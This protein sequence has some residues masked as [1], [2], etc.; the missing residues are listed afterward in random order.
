MSDETVQGA[1]PEAGAAW[2]RDGEQRVTLLFTDIV[3]STR[4][5]Q[6]LGDRQGVE[7]IQSHHRLV[8]E[9]LAGFP[10]AAVAGTSG[11]SFLIVFA[12]PA[13]AVA[14]AL[15]LQ[16]RLREDAV[17]ES[18]PVFDRVGIHTG[19]VVVERKGDDIDVLGSDVDAA[20]RVMG[21]AEADQ[22]LISEEAC[23]QAR[24]G[25]DREPPEG[26]RK[27]RWHKHGAYR[28]R[29]LK[30]AVPVWEVGEDGLARFRTPRRH[31]PGAVPGY[32]WLLLL[33]GLLAGGWLLERRVPDRAS[34]ARLPT[35]TLALVPEVDPTDPAAERTLLDGIAQA[36]L[37]RLAQRKQEARL[38]LRLVP[39]ADVLE[40]RITGT[41]EARKRFGAT[42]VLVARW[43][44]DGALTRLS[45]TLYDAT[46]EDT[47]RS[48]LLEARGSNLLGVAQIVA[49]RTLAWLQFGPLRPLPGMAGRMRTV[50]PRAYRLYLQGVGELARYDPSLQASN[51]VA[52]LT[53]ATVED[54]AFA[55]AFAA[56]GE[57]QWWLYERTQDRTQIEEALAS[58]LRAMELATN[59]LAPAA[60]TLGLVRLG[61]GQAAL[62]AEAFQRA[63]AV[64]P[65]YT[66]ARTMLARAHEEAG[67]Y[68]TAEGIHQ[69]AVSQ[70]AGDWRA[71]HSLGVFYANRTDRYEQA[72]KCFRRVIELTPDNYAG[73]ANLGGL[74]FL[75]GRFAEAAQW[76]EQ[77]I[78][79]KPTAQNCS[80][81]ATI[82]FFEGEYPDAVALALQATELDPNDHVWWG[83]LADARRYA[84]P[85]SPDA[86]AAYRHAIALAEASLRVN[87]R[88]PQVRADLAVYH[89]FLD[90]PAAAQAAIA[91]TLRV[92]PRDPGV[93]FSLAL[94]QER[95]GN[96]SA[97]LQFLRDALHAGYPRHNMIRHPD[98]KS[99]REDAAAT[100]LLAPPA[101]NNSQPH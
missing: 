85:A 41:T 22:I 4:L 29:G 73:Y 77:S 26:L 38:P 36:S 90:E 72:E 58:T 40:E 56:L 83:N 74:L 44:R 3:G 49:D 5:K 52:E 48:E 30:Q 20:A 21:L 71:W 50:N 15:R 89:A 2:L 101:E 87:P 31:P 10:E 55:L 69:E 7:R 51:A 23:A 24:P 27:S 92:A 47:L 57:A 59:V 32:A 86:T 98:L 19:T 82:L 37:E 9:L 35:V 53:A 81:L 63:L 100:D 13:I 94:A 80:N 11:D 42:H 70:D 76:L 25:L 62:A 64:D 97:A 1:G 60:Y 28:L 39:V 8:R 43:F 66:R 17:G 65:A 78:K 6:V 96:R 75:Q 45:I 54:P 99:L 33:G 93:L 95:A 67:D 14:F 91:E 84:D 61:R 46:H 12:R 18:H 79:L 88:Q 16:R 34:A 68:Q